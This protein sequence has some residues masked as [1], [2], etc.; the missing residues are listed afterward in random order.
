AV[1]ADEQPD[2]LVTLHD[3]AERAEGAEPV[4]RHCEILDVE[5]R[6]HSKRVGASAGG[7]AAILAPP[8]R[9]GHGTRPRRL[10]P[11]PMSPRGN[12]MITPTKSAPRMIGHRRG[13]VPVSTLRS[14]LMETAPTSAPHSVP[15]P[16]NA[17]QMTISSDGKTPIWEG[18]MM[19]T[20]GA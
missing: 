4:E 3:E 10:S 15:L 20:W 9:G 5:E 17:T 19:P 14:Q 2:A 16:P 12:S 6:L 13:Y 1:G 18:V 7:G 8:R 11:S